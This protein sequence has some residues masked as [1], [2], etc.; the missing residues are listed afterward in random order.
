[1]TLLHVNYKEI[2]SRINI[3]QVL[4]HYGVLGHLREKGDNL[5]GCCPIHQ[6]TNANQFHASRTKSLSE[7]C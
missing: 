7:T 3:A 6:G 2:K 5:I 1:M 4:N